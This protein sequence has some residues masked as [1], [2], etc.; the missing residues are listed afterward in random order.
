MKNETTVTVTIQDNETTNT[1]KCLSTVFGG[2]GTQ[3]S[4]TFD[5]G[6]QALL[7]AMV[8]HGFDPESVSQY[9]QAI[10]K[11]REEA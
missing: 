2:Y 6:I 3:L 1:S 8:A 4:C 5:A 7:G 10:D 11:A 9:G